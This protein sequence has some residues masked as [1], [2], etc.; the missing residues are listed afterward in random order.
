MLVNPG[1]A[2]PGSANEVLQCAIWMCRFPIC[3]CRFHIWICRFPIWICIFSDV[4][5]QISSCCAG[6]THKVSI[7]AKLDL[8]FPGLD[9]QI[10]RFRFADS[11]IW[12]CRFSDF[13]VHVLF[14]F[15]DFRLWICIFPTWI[16][17]NWQFSKPLLAKP[18]FP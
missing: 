9:L 5:L 17:R 8:Q 2:K 12:I 7:S 13:N 6:D 11:P 15:S 18:W 3:I 16:C 10:F 1:S 14:G 4:D